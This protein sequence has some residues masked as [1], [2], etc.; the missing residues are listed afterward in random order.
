MTPFGKRYPLCFRKRTYIKKSMIKL[1]RK[2]AEV[3]Y[4]GKK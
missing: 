1:A 4:G 2:W 3:E